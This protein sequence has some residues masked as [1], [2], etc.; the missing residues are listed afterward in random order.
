M[1]ATSFHKRKLRTKVHLSPSSSPNY[2]QRGGGRG[3]KEDAPVQPKSLHH[4]RTGHTGR[5]RTTN[6]GTGTRTLDTDLSS[7]SGRRRRSSS[8]F[9]LLR[10]YR[11]FGFF[12][13]L[14]VVLS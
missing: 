5:T 3:A 9:L 14:P 11:R 12:L 2:K 6:T 13:A 4:P 8:S 7:T 10:R 1:H